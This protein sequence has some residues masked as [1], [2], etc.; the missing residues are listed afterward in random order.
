M[1]HIGFIA[2]TEQLYELGISVAREMDL[3]DGVLFQR[4]NLENSLEAARQMERE[5]FDVIISRGGTAELL[6]T[7][8]AHTPLVTI[9]ITSH[10]LN[11]A[12][13]EAKSITG[14]GHPRVALL[15]FRNMDEN[16]ELFAKVLGVNIRIYKIE[17]NADSISTTLRQAQS[18][19]LDVVVGGELTTALCRKWG[20][21]YVKLTSNPDSVRKAFNE[22]LR[23]SRRVRFERERSRHF[24]ALVDIIRDGIL[25]VNAEGCVQIFNPAALE[26]LGCAAPDLQGKN[27]ES[28]LAI[29][30]FS[31]TMLPI[32]NFEEVL[33]LPHATALVSYTPMIIDD[34]VGGAM[35]LLQETQ[36]V[37]QMDAKI[38]KELHTR[39]M[40]AV[41]KFSDI[42]GT[43]P[44]IREARRR[45]SVFAA[46]R[47]TVLIYGE[48]GTGK[49]LFAQAM[50][51]AS[52]CASGPF[53][54]VNC[55]ALPPSLLE[56][57]LF[58]YDEG[59]FTG[60]NRKGKVGLIEL[61][62][63]GT[64][65]LDEIS[66][67]DHYGQVRL[68]R[69]MQE[70]KI[71]RVGGDKYLPVEVRIIAASNRDLGRLVR[72]GQFRRDLYYR[73]HVLMLRLPALRERGGDVGWLATKLVEQWSAHLG[74]HFT[75]SPE[76]LVR[77]ERHNWP[78]NVRELANIIE[79]LCTVCTGRIIS[80]GLVKSVLDMHFCGLDGDG[81]GGAGYDG[82]VVGGTV[83]DGAALD[84]L[85]F[86]G[87]DAALSETA[88]GANA[89]D[90]ATAYKGDKP[91]QELP[92]SE[93]MGTKES[94]SHEREHILRSLRD[95]NGNYREAARCLGMHRSTL[96]RK[97]RRYGIVFQPE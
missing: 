78:G 28:V 32:T 35:I 33:T 71:M 64:L 22:A 60:A 73:M 84:G 62:H 41:Y 46:T 74:K 96:Y 88:R 77:L 36:R 25:Y 93:Q 56:S 21:K 81:L 94:F 5:N 26:L 31:S 61:A 75:F 10:E 48:T 15:T 92:V 2:P 87:L 72:A 57:E 19:G 44:K 30:G 13:Y 38:R 55:A 79:W 65:F 69:F 70:R 52:P 23:V 40:V 53:V 39:G 45:A 34:A 14:L 18:H 17:G 7:N 68:L 8:L 47:S 83:P 24:K 1:P 12:V 20:I 76:A 29:P 3:Q 54:A 42:Q 95:C 67:M 80:D 97:I 43:S 89:N 66:E 51:H 4:A 9:D 11:E 50:H 90:P 82:A 27:L 59:A 91:M 16:I 85:R 49:E 58:G 6:S 63:M 37:T 86:D